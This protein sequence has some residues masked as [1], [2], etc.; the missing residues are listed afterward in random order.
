LDRNAAVLEVEYGK[1]HRTGRRLPLLERNLLNA[2]GVRSGKVLAQSRGAAC[3]R[4][5]TTNRAVSR[6]RAI[7]GCTGPRRWRDPNSNGSNRRAGA[8]SGRRRWIQWGCLPNRLDDTE[9]PLPPSA[10]AKSHAAKLDKAPQRWRVGQA[11]PTWLGGI[12]GR[13]PACMRR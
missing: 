5:G 9:A 8:V 4:R 10:G 11:K 3:T 2:P 13:K 6:A 7:R 1:R 12:S